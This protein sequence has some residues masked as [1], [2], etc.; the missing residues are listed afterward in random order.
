[1]RIGIH[2]GS[3]LCGVI[4][5]RKWQFDVWSKDVTL[6]NAMEQAGVAGRVHI[7]E[8]TLRYLNRAYEVEEADGMSRNAI[9]RD[10]NMCTYFI[11]VP[12]TSNKKVNIDKLHFKTSRLELRSEFVDFTVCISSGF[13]SGN[14]VDSDRIAANASGHNQSECGRGESGFTFNSGQRT[15]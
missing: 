12:D 13:E 10:H 7:S 1:M 11:K 6:A 14:A 3:V 4:G 15:R 9:I 2:S 5:L 8:S